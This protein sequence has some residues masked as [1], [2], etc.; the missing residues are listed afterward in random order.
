MLVQ[1]LSKSTSAS[2]QLQLLSITSSLAAGSAEAS[3]SL[4]DAGMGRVLLQIIG[5][6][7]LPRTQVM[8][9]DSWYQCIAV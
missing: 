9:G 1:L 4:A 3:S 5:G 7:P 6:T 2:K 8:T